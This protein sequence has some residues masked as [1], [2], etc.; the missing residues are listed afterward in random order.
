MKE[1]IE[2]KLK[3][4]KK[5]ARGELCEDCPNNE[6]SVEWYFEVSGDPTEIT[7]I[8]EKI[9]KIRPARHRRYLERRV[10]FLE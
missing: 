1:L 6:E 2:L 5:I 4:G 7:E 10:K 8:K 3:E 9:S